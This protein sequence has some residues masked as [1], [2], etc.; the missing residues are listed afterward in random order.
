M[1]TEVIWRRGLEPITCVPP[2]RAAIS[3]LTLRSGC[4]ATA[5]PTPAWTVGS[6]PG[7]SQAGVE[8]KVSGSFQTGAQS[9]QMEGYMSDE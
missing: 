3:W 2:K 9:R 6:G 7:S 1:S 4:Q 5:P 8:R